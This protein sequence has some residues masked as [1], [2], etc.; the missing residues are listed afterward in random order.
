MVH[1][2][3]RFLQRPYPKSKDSLVF[4]L[5]SG[6]LVA[7]FLYVFKP[8]GLS[9]YSGDLLR[10][11]IGYGLVTFV[12]TGLL[13]TIH[14]LLRSKLPPWTVGAEILV[15]CLNLLFIAVGNA[16]FT[17]MV[18]DN[19]FGWKLLLYFIPITVAVGLVPI[20]FFL[21]LREWR[22]RKA[23][24]LE[25][26]KFEKLGSQETEQSS[27]TSKPSWDLEDV[28]LHHPLPEIVHFEAQGNFLVYRLRNSDRPHTLNGYRFSEI[29]A[30]LE[31]HPD[32]LQVHR[33]HVIRLSG[34]RSVEG[35]ARGLELI[36]ENKDTVP[37]ARSRIEVFREVYQRR[38]GHI[39]A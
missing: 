19:P 36:L 1:A 13:G 10:V 38:F 5:S 9:N 28:P 29:A 2:L 32:Y 8:F 21:F 11:S 3:L 39:P 31:G 23:F 18:W 35:N 16:W 33:S 15:I 25:A 7:L 6:I 26:Q 22:L 24:Q 12:C 17:S 37:V 27:Q 14:Y 30:K 20:L 34:V 4:P